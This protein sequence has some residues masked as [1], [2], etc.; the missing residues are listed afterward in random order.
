MKKLN[1]FIVSMALLLAMVSP[2]FAATD[3]TKVTTSNVDVSAAIKAIGGTPGKINVRLNDKCIAFTDA[4]PELQNGSTMVPLRAL[5]ESMGAKVENLT[6]G[7][8]KISIGTTVIDL[9]VGDKAVSVQKAEGDKQ[10]LTLA[11]A[12]YIN[13]DRT[14][15][16]L[17]FVSEV[18]GYDVLWDQTYQTVV[19]LDGKSIIAN[20]D[21]NFTTLNAYFKSQSKYLTGNW[22]SE[23]TMELSLEL[24]DAANGNKTFTIPGKMTSHTG[25]GAVNAEVSIDCS[26]LLPMLT[27]MAGSDTNVLAMLQSVA[28]TQTMSIRLLPDGGMYV[29]SGLYDMLAAQLGSNNTGKETWYNIGKITPSALTAEGFTLGNIFYSSMMETAKQTGAFYSY[30]MMIVSTQMMQTVMGDS[31]FQKQGDNYVWTMDKAKLAAMTG[32]KEVADLFQELNL[33]L[34]FNMNGTY[35]MTGT[36]KINIADLSAALSMSANGNGAT[37]TTSM[38]LSI[39]DL[40]NLKMKAN[41][42]TWEVKDA[43]QVALPQGATV[44]DWFDM[45]MK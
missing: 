14:Y 20:M 34:T 7:S 13:G 25:G 28:K 24:I 9:K 32:S 2:A 33:K 26:S 4:F 19:V 39:K 22:K 35:T 18:F 16:P 42:K 45:L 17:R 29:K 8:I 23:G 36:I 5:V 43:P 44:V 6:D 30:D 12:P 21:K 40:F 37:D 1:A 31:T 10:T 11:V 38:E 3:L 15:V 27:K 41:S